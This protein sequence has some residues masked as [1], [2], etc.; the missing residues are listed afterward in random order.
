MKITQAAERTSEVGKV[1]Y[2]TGN[3][4][5]DEI[6]VG[7]PPST[8]R[9]HSVTFSP[10][11]RTAWHTHP[12][13]QVLHVLSGVG[14]VQVHGDPL[15]EIGPGDEV[16]IAAGECHWHGAAPDRV[17]VHIAVQEATPD[18]KEAEWF[19]HVS[20]RDYNGDPNS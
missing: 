3:V 7:E 9:V 6:A 12:V 2:F 15:R 11:A 13:G 10:G 19:E 20:D 18:G 4:W 8:L 17:L 14:R 16:W 1:E 5:L